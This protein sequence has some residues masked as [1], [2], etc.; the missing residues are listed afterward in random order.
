MSRAADTARARLRAA[1]VEQAK[2]ARRKRITLVAAGV[3]ALVLVASLTTGGIIVASRAAWATGVPTTA[4]ADHSGIVV[5]PGKAKDSAP[6]FVVY[7]DYQ[8]PWCKKF[9]E[10]FDN[11]IRQ[12]ADQGQFRL[13]YRTMTFLDH[14]LGNDSSLRA[15]IA[16]ACADSV[17]S[18]AFYHK[19]IYDNQ[20]AKE[21]QGYTNEQLRNIF[22]GQAG[23]AGDKL[24]TFQAC[25]D[26]QAMRA[27]VEGTQE[28]AS[29]AGIKST[30]T[31][32]FNGKDITSLLNPD[33]QASLDA[34]LANR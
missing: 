4:N 21:G 2:K 11:A 16:A 5:N 14:N 13:E 1:Q 26:A 31:Y 19:T 23:I 15:G 9:D 25:Y 10:T 3:V 30:P 27:F 8:C 32:V 34:A 28:A 22:P 18:L 12:R 7:Q 17:G 29:K 33:N 24:T 6:L 20:P